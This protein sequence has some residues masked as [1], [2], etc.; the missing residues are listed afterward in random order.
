MTLVVHKN[1]PLTKQQIK[2]IEKWVDDLRSGNS[3][4][5]KEVLRR[6]KEGKVV[7]YCCLGRVCEIYKKSTRKGEWGGGAFSLKEEKF[8]S[9]G[10]LRDPVMEWL[11]IG[12]RFQGKCI[13]M[14]DL[15]NKSFKQIAKAIEKAVKDNTF[16]I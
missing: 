3:K 11:G 14:N 15:E 16:H 1:S 7:G 6:I 13:D 12:E 8:G 4:Q 5:T 9:I 10:S 2:R